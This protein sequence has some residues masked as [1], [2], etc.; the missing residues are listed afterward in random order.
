MN[1]GMRMLAINNAR[2]NRTKMNY[3]GGTVDSSPYMNVPGMG[4][5]P[6]MRGE[7]EARFRDD[8][9]R[10]R[11]NNGRYAPM[12]MG[13]RNGNRSGSA[14]TGVYA[15]SAPYYE[16]E[17]VETRQMN[18]PIGFDMTGD[19]REV[20]YEPGNEMQYHHGSE[21]QRGRAEHKHVPRF[22]MD[23]AR[24]WTDGIKNDDGTKGPHWTLEQ[25]R[26]IMQQKGIESDPAEFFA[27]INAIYADYCKVAKQHNVGTIDFYV[28]LAKAWLDDKDAV[29]NK[30][31]AYYEY[32]VKHE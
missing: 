11:Y 22:D 14:G 24:E 17:G 6:E 27:V 30:A 19:R 12:G 13:S 31:A 21:P 23:T 28:D 16:R 32:V 20:E 9:G 10:E 1:A 2:R 4:I 18:R 7:Q 29:P 3:G 26:P 5:Y 25:L 15:G 8:R